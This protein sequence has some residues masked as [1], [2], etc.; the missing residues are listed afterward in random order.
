MSRPKRTRLDAKFIEDFAK[1][2]DDL[3]S[4]IKKQL[5]FSVVVFV[6]LASNYLGIGLGLS[7]FGFSLTNAPGSCR[8]LTS[9]EQLDH[10]LHAAAAGKCVPHRNCIEARDFTSRPGR[11]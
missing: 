10:L 8:R 11:A 5:I 7:A 4:Q 2:R 6:Y 1:A 9:G 3:L